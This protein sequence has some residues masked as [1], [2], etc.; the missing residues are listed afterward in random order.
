MSAP[1]TDKFRLVEAQLGSSLATYLHKAQ[2]DGDS[3]RKIATDLTN[4][5]GVEVSHET[6][7]V[8]LSTA[9]RAAS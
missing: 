7:R 1:L 4:T 9:E 2:A 5:S 3:L 8:W 6:V